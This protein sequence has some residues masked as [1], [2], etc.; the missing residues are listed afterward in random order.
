MTAVRWAWRRR[1]AFPLIAL[2]VALLACIQWEPTPLGVVIVA[3]TPIA[4]AMVL[5]GVDCGVPVL[6]WRRYE[7]DLIRS[8]GRHPAQKERTPA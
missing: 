2:V 3:V 4:V 7:R 1:R 8:I 5:A 6:R